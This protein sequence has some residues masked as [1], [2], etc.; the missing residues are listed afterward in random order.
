MNNTQWKPKSELPAVGVTVLTCSDD[1]GQPQSVSFCR[2]NGEKWIDMIDDDL[3]EPSF[4]Y[5][6]YIPELP[7]QEKA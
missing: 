3:S 5:W 6:M 2:Y 4:D 7:K 1:E